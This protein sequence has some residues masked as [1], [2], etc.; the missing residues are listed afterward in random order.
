[1]E[2]SGTKAVGRCGV[3]L[4]Y[5]DMSDIGAKRTCGNPAVTPS[6]RCRVHDP[7]TAPK[8]DRSGRILPKEPKPVL[9]PN[10]VYLADG[11]STI[12]LHCAGMSALYTGRDLSGQK[13]Q[14]VDVRYVKEWARIVAENSDGLLS[15]PLKCEGGCTT[16]SPIAGADGWPLATVKEVRR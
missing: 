1:M 7:A 16:L 14:R 3:A 10:A 11:G 13:V 12:C 15:G 4:A 9:K 6:G 8:R 2:T 5:R